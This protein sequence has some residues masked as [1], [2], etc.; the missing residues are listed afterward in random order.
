MKTIKGP[1]IFLAQF[2][3]DQAPFNSLPA[4]GEWAAD[5][6]YKG[7]QIPSWDGRLFDLAKAAES[8]TY[9]DEVKGTLA[10][11]GVEITELSTHLQGQ[12]VA[13]HPAYDEA[14]DGFAAPEVRGNPKARQEWAVG[15]LMLAAQA[16][17]NLG[18]TA[19]ATFSGALAWPY[20]YPWPQRP[21]GLIETAFDEL[22]KRWRP[23]LD[24]FDRAGVDLC[25][26]IHPGEDLFDGATFEMFLE[27][28]GNHPRCN[29]LYDPS[30][31]VLQQLDY[32]GYIDVYH[33]RIK[34]FHAKDAEFN[35]SPRQGVYSGY[36]PWI[37]R[38]G[39]FRSLGDGQV[40]FGAI[41]SK[42]TQYGYDGWAVLEWECCMKHPEQG[43]A[44][45]APFIEAHIIRTTE[46]AFDDFA[47]TGTDL[48]ANRR[49]LGIG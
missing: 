13:V 23:I 10:D 26:E 42:L 48:E 47:G 46:K 21:A 14:F 18:L 19:H 1:A 15:Q 44:E 32:L 41:F 11:L 37:N 49:M 43:A 2:A 5:L 31:F 34:M 24:A 33:E 35:P 45:G 3:G 12:L 27:R 29:I 25:Y 30:H 28:V 38:A 8:R 20:I 22:A 16:S 40:D 6:G 9:C 36:Q 39:R 7:V 4:I 17:A